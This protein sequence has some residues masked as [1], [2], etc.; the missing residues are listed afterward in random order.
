MIES[1]Q[2]SEVWTPTE[3]TFWISQRKDLRYMERKLIFLFFLF[4]GLWVAKQANSTRWKPKLESK[5]ETFCIFFYESMVSV[6]VLAAFFC[7]VLLFFFRNL[8]YELVLPF[9]FFRDPQKEK[10]Y[11]QTCKKCSIRGFFPYFCASF[12]S[13]ILLQTKL[14]QSSLRPAYNNHCNITAVKLLTTLLKMC[15]RAKWNKLLT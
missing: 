13:H 7:F 1:L 8:Y 4:F 6:S 9:I 10:M 12:I 2:A 15:T 5:T 14:I 11:P 3:H